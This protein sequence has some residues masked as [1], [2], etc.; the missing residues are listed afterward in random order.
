MSRSTFLIIYTAVLV[1]LVI[2]AFFPYQRFNIAIKYSTIITIILG[3]V[4]IGMGIRL[5]LYIR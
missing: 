5:A 4:A 2:S 3:V 1:I